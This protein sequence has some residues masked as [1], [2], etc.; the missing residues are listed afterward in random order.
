MTSRRARTTS[1]SL[2]AFA[3][4]RRPRAVAAPTRRSGGA[5][6]RRT[7]LA[8]L[9]VRGVLDEY[10]LVYREAVARHRRRANPL[11]AVAPA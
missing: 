11:R 1:S 5:E 10:E 4:P 2:R 8:D 3:R 7:A 9:S 6:V